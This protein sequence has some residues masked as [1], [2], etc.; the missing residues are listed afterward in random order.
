MLNINCFTLV[1]AVQLISCVQLF[2]TPRTASYQSLLSFTISQSSLK[3]MSV[4]SVMPS[5]HIIPFH[6][7]LLLPSIFPNISV[8][9]KESAL[10]IRCLKYWSFS[11]HS[12]N[13]NLGLISFRIDWFDLLEAEGTLKSLLQ[14]HN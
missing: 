8:F 3:L 1:I 4:D 12:S 10:C 2:V 7:L 9:S 6:P 14:L 11:I 13:E 5:N